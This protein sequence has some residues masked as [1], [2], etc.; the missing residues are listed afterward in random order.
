[1]RINGY[2]KGRTYKRIAILQ[3]IANGDDVATVARAL[4]RNAE[5]LEKL[6]ARVDDLEKQLKDQKAATG[7][8][9]K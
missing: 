8:G 6:I 9:K 4:N 3:R 2:D 5:I 7:E 1:M